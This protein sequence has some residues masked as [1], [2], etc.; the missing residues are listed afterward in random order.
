M[1]YLSA[2][3]PDSISVSLCLSLSLSYEYQCAW[4]SK[5]AIESESVRYSV[6]SD[7]LQPLESQ[8]PLYTEFS[9]KEYWS[10]L[11]SPSPGD[12]PNPDIKPGFNT[13]QA[14]SLPSELPGKM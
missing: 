13:L 7:S 11:L 9:R 12:L 8:A 14:Y 5:H 3:L 2:S 6:V 4:S 1:P 10:G